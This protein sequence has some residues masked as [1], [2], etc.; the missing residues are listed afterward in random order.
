MSGNRAQAHLEVQAM[1]A[2]VQNTEI[3]PDSAHALMLGSLTSYFHR[4]APQQRMLHDLIDGRTAISLRLLDWFVTHYAKKNNVLYW[5]D[6]QSNFYQDL[7]HGANLRKFTVY[8]EYRAQLRA[9]SKHAFDPFRRHNRISFVVNERQDG[10]PIF[11]DTTIGQLNFFRWA[12]QNKV[13]DYVLRNLSTVEDD[14]ATFQQHR[15]G[16]YAA[17]S[18]S[19]GAAVSEGQST[20]PKEVKTPVSKSTTKASM[21]IDATKPLQLPTRVHFD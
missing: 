18:N 5:L 19:S 2:D 14:M 3:P 13:I 4:N 11:V 15:R 10:T 1:A 16:T 9:F 6:A 21:K 8:T 17:V 7:P 20:P 12:L